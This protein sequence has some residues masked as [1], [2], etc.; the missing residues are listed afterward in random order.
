LISCCVCSDSP[1]WLQVSQSDIF[2]ALDSQNK[3]KIQQYLSST[4]KTSKT[5]NDTASSDQ[6]SQQQQ[7]PAGRVHKPSHVY[8]GAE[9]PLAAA[10]DAPMSWIATAQSKQQQQ[11]ESKFSRSSS[12]SFVQS[13]G[14]LTP[15]S[16]EEY[17]QARHR[18]VQD[19]VDR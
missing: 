19:I 13:G 7:Q 6:A 9:L 14:E 4:E 12:G 11:Q 17:G 15:E 5:S 3:A 18:L 10:P 1:V 16:S 8:C 2:K